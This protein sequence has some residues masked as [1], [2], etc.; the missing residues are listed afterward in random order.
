V[1]PGA[2]YAGRRRRAAAALSDLDADGLV[3][4]TLVNVRYLT[5]FTG[6]NAVYLLRAG[7]TGTLLTDGRYRDQAASETGAEPVVARN[8]IATAAEQLKGTWACETHTLTVDL[9]QELESSPATLIPAG[10]IVE[11]LREVKDDDEIRTLERACSISVEALRG[12]IEAD[13]FAGRTER[14]V[15][16]DL[17]QRMYDAGA[18][19]LAFETILASG[20]N[21][22]IPHHRPT[23][24][25]LQGGDLVKID[26]GARVDGYHAD[27]TR[28][29]VVGRASA[30]QKE[31]HAAVQKAQAAGVSALRAG[32]EVNECDRVA[33]EVLEAAGWLEYFTTGIGHGVGLEI[34]E[35]PFVGRRSAG[36]LAAGTA[37]TM[38]PGIYVPDRGGVRIE[39]TVIVDDSPRVLTT[40]TT[41]LLEIA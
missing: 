37:L 33:R 20:P 1:T 19:A 11:T 35:D 24:R 18:D 31:I 9:H 10:R 41:D 12:L 2:D 40:L 13:A 15:A 16:R 36:T 32:A 30:W 27:C 29:L 8:V 5:G 21:S 34:H 4:S 28:T 14:Q 3:V 7:G 22:A 39:D 6:S 26:F 25:V 23:D 17:E 38:E